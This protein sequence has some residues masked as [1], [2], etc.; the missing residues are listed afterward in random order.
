MGIVSLVHR[1]AQKTRF[2]T[3]ERARLKIGCLQ[4]L[5][6]YRPNVLYLMVS[7]PTGAN[8][9]DASASRSWR[10]YNYLRCPIRLRYLSTARSY[11]PLRSG[12]ISSKVSWDG[13]RTAIQHIHP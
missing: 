13:F 5:S 7:R 2:N 4:V 12:L 9:L 1:S 10:A 8:V 11:A 3:Y 6:R